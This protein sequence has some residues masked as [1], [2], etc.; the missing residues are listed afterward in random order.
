M[1]DL[2]GWLSQIYL[3]VLDLHD[4]YLGE[5]EKREQLLKREVEL[6]SYIN[7][8]A[9]AYCD[10]REGNPIRAALELSW[11]REEI[12]RE[13]ARYKEY[14]KKSLRSVVM[15]HIA[16]AIEVSNEHDLWGLSYSKWKVALQNHG[17]KK[18][19]SQSHFYDLR[20]Q[21]GRR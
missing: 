1:E 14:V 17:L 11:H 20:K 7:G 13:V 5:P 19:P 4:S 15:E 3:Q 21:Y 16:R 2:P 6:L 8:F 18:I 12:E 10:T 9:H